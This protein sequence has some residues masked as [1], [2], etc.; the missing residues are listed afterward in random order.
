MIATSKNFILLQ[1][2]VDI[3]RLFLLYENGGMWLDTNSF[4]VRDLNWIENIEKETTP[5]NRISN[6]PDV[7]TF[8]YNELFGGNKSR[9][10][11]EDSGE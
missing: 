8:T 9:V 7:I 2:H 1:N 3:F 5:Y 11:D 6:D 10:I 4:F